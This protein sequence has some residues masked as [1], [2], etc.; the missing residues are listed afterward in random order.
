M[1]LQ[2][3]QARRLQSAF[4]SSWH[5]VQR[6]NKPTYNHHHY[7][8]SSTS[9][10]LVELAKLHLPQHRVL[11]AI[12]NG[13]TVAVDGLPADARA[14]CARQEHHTRCDLARLRR[15]AHWRCELL[16]RLLVHRGRDQ[17]RPHRPRCD[18]VCAD[19]LAEVLVGE[20]AGEGDDGSLGRSIVEQ[21]RSADVGV[22]GGVVD[23]G[24]A[25][26][27]VWEKVFGEV[28]HRMDV[29]IESVY[30]LVPDICQPGD[31][32]PLQDL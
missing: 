30:P 7:N 18:G 26:L 11:S 32:G 1:P 6:G 22:D 25:V 8:T 10:S 16:L 24:A 21:I 17:R 23:D 29:H 19:A 5:A 15:P 2:W 4:F 20:A 9:I 12:D 3:W 31:D 28:E 13:A 14:V 27:H